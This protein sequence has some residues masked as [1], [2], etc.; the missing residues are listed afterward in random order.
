MA[1]PK[2]LTTG[3]HV[4]RWRQSFQ[5]SVAQ[6]DSEGACST[7]S[8]TM[9]RDDWN[10]PRDKGPSELEE[11]KRLLDEPYKKGPKGKKPFTIERRYIGPTGNSFLTKFYETYREWH[12]DRRYATERARAEAFE[13]L[14]RRQG[15]SYPVYE[16][17][18]YRLV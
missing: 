14:T 17:W 3:A 10:E 7:R 1:G 16:R 2:T 15:N 12:V 13:A 5:N 6:F 8:R 18:E 11:F 9:S 4:P